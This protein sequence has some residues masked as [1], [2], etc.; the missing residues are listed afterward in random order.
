MVI[1]V[2]GRLRQ[3]YSESEV[4]LGYIDKLCHKNQNN[5]KTYGEMYTSFMQKPHSFI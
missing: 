3:E 2:C 4:S 1:L 5:K